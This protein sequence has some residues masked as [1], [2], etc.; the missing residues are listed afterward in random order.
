[1][2]GEPIDDFSPERIQVYQQFCSYFENPIMTKVKDDDKFSTY[3]VKLYCLLSKECR[4]L[5]A[6]MYRTIDVIGTQTRLS[7]I[8]WISFQ[9]RTLRESF[10]CSTHSFIVNSLHEFSTSAIERKEVT[11]EASSYI[12]LSL[13]IIVTLL[14]TKNKTAES[15]Q[16]SGT[17][18]LA[19]ETFE[20]VITFQ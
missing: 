20:T 18:M 7:D 16:K 6:I 8:E 4:Y 15:Y 12:A 3:A 5:I 1:M 9:T 10:K 2:Y 17:V 11:K 13:P 19:L 14:H